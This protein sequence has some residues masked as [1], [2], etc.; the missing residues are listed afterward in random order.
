MNPKVVVSRK[1]H[2]KNEYLGATQDGVSLLERFDLITACLLANV[3][4]LQDK[5]AGP[6]EV[7]DGLRNILHV[8]D[9]ASQVVVSRD[10]LLLRGRQLLPEVDDGLHL[11]AHQGV[12][13]RDERLVPG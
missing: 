13:L 3:E 6:M 2:Q 7:A 11:R 9:D 10:L 8:A 1:T 5:I 4:V 12:R